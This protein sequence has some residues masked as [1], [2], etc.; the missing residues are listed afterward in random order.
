MPA[1][2]RAALVDIARDEGEMGED[3]VRAHVARM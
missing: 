1:G 2:V 3:D